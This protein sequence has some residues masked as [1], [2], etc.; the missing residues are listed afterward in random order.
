VW[1][2]LRCVKTIPVVWN[3]AARDATDGAARQAWVKRSA[4]VRTA[5]REHLKRLE[6]QKLKARDRRGYEEHRDVST[7]S[8]DWERVAAWPRRSSMPRS[9]PAPQPLAGQEDVWR[10]R[11]SARRLAPLLVLMVGLTGCN[12]APKTDVRW[13]IQY[14]DPC[15]AVLVVT[16]FAAWGSRVTIGDH[17]VLLENVGTGV[18]TIELRQDEV[19]AAST[20]A[21]AVEKDGKTRTFQAAVPAPPAG[22]GGK[23]LSAGVRPGFRWVKGIEGSDLVL[24]TE[25]CNVRRAEPAAGRISIDPNGLIWRLPLEVVWDQRL[26]RGLDGS[27]YTLPHVVAGGGDGRALT[28]EPVVPIPQVLA[29]LGR[30]Y[31]N[32]PLTAAPP[33]R[34]GGPILAVGDVVELVHPPPTGLAL[35]DVVGLAVAEEKAEEIERCEYASSS[36]TRTE[37]M[38]RRLD[39]SVVLYEARTGHKLGS[40]VLQGE[41][42]P[43]CSDRVTVYTGSPGDLSNA[44]PMEYSLAV[45]AG[46]LDPFRDFHG[47]RPNISRWLAQF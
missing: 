13:R 22:I 29:A 32:H 47:G 46:A 38:R 10:T 5:L 36:G 15:Q 2:I 44:S 27:F 19:G 14:D 24:W 28:L 35:R 45:A 43:R 23:P 21:I 9:R 33:Y 7:E 42:P 25:A 34:R 16:T 37:R 12:R 4:L 3:S 8:S 1:H 31:P 30:A 18:P 6:T 26:D 11:V 17:T 40:T 20:L 41:T 39:M